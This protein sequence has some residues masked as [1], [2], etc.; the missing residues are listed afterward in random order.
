M[1]DTV[2]AVFVPLAVALGLLLLIAAGWR[3]Y[4]MRSGRSRAVAA[5]LRAS[6][7]ATDD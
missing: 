4:A 6:A 1:S 3:L 7:K 5:P 2:R